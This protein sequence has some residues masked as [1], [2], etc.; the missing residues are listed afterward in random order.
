M[1]Q[2]RGVGSDEEGLS[3]L[4]K[5]AYTLPRQLDK[6][7]QTE[8]SLEDRSLGSPEVLEDRKTHQSCMRKTH[9]DPRNEHCCELKELPSVCHH[10]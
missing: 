10:H 9:T 8:T 3:G 6:D 2:K 7:H 5:E 1:R 4:S